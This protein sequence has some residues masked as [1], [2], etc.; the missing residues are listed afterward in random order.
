MSRIPS[1][2]IFLSLLSWY[3]YLPAQP[4]PPKKLL[5]VGNSYTYF[6]NLPQHVAA[7]A[8]SQDIEMVCQQSSSGGASLGN[9][10]RGEKELESIATIKEGQFDVIILTAP[11]YLYSFLLNL[12]P[13]PLRFFSQFPIQCISWSM[14]HKGI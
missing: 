14:G 5:F 6:W 2:L 1:L 3:L 13:H 8:E 7:M 10:W 12:F 11:T 4:T 9:H